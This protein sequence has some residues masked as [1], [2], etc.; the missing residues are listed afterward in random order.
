MT[1]GH[2]GGPCTMPSS[3]AGTGG[4]QETDSGRGV[5]GSKSE[6]LRAT[7]S[8]TFLDCVVVGMRTVPVRS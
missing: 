3:V 1:C 4:H 8:C 7:E 6:A 5:E 2:H